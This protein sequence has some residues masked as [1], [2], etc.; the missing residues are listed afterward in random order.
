[1]INGT[2]FRMTMEINRQTRLSQEIARSQAEITAGKRIL[3][4]SD[5][6]IGAARVTELNR[7]QATE[8]VWLR[9]ADAAMALADRADSTLGSVNNALDRAKELML[10]AANGTM[11]AD[12]RATIA[13]ELQ[14][15]AEEIASLR[16]TVDARGEPLFRTNGALEIPVQEGVRIS[17]VPD[18]NSI[19]GSSSDIVSV[20]TAAAA[21]V[22]E[23]DPTLRGPAMQAS[24]TAIDTANTRVVN[25]RGEVGVQAS[26]LDKI[27]D[28]L[29]DSAI[30]LEEQKGQI[31]DVDLAGAVNRISAKQVSL[32]AA[33]AIFA[34]L[35]RQTL[36]DQL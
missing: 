25:S 26:R 29:S 12:N 34:R 2:S 15:I 28:Q 3:A 1:M 13:L 4:P 9:N 17:P 23:P 14:G 11:S 22:V 20:I 5:D 10:S 30:Q 19:F 8:A 33:Q 6:P 27:R 35:S 21:A 32:A 16:G 7:T 36:F 31:E 18:R 24:M